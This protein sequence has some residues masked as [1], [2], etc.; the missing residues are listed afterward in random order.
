MATIKNLLLMNSVLRRSMKG[1]YTTQ[2]IKFDY[3]PMWKVKKFYIHL[4]PMK[5]WN[6]KGFLSIFVSSTEKTAEKFSFKVLLFVVE[7]KRL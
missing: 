3:L 7:C 6:L 1:Y 5:K 2:Q 4:L